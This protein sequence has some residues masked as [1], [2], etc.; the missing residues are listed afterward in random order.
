MATLWTD[1]LQAH[2]AEVRDNIAEATWRL[3]QEHG[4]M[5]LT[6]SQVAAASGISRATLYKYF[7]D[8][9]AI[10]T[11]WHHRQVQA[12]LDQ[13]VAAR[14]GVD[15]PEA[16]LRA[17]LSVYAQVCRTR[18][19]HGPGTLQDLLHQ[20]RDLQPA[21]H[22]LEDLVREVLAAAA[23]AGAVRDDRPPEQLTAYCLHALTAAADLPGV[24]DRHGL[25]E[26][27]LAGLRPPA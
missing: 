7:P 14:D 11:D 4:V 25:V 3:A 13:L 27:V 8:V 26:I 21:Q 17:V 24:N 19:E 9:Q 16:R 22:R 6:M 1:S 23:D 5:T 10:L 15:D 12:H 2:R 18:A 20:D